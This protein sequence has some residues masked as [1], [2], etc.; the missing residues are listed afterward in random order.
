MAN[1]AAEFLLRPGKKTGHVFKS[2]QRY[3]EGITEAHEARALYG[4]A[5]IEHASEKRRLIG[6]E[7]C[8]A[9]IQPGKA[10]DEI[11]GEMFVHLKK[12]TVVHDGVNRVFNVVRPLRI[13]RHQCVQ[14]FVAA[15]GAIES[16]AA[17][18]VLEIIGG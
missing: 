13:V 16:C 3:V 17:R 1:D 15:V 12:I 8:R 6:D 10:Y 14:R 2:N 18:R 5:D 7:A 11:L 9:A 4:S